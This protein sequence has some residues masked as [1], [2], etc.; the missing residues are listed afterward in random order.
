MGKVY[1]KK[2]DLAYIKGELSIREAAKAFGVAKSSL[3]NRLLGTVKL[4]NFWFR[5]NEAEPNCF[6]TVDNFVYKHSE[7]YQ[8]I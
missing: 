4:S 3:S 1:R 8:V 6:S 5:R 7:H 2:I